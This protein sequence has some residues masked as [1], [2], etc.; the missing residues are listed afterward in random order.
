M[1]IKK[2]VPELLESVDAIKKAIEKETDKEEKAKLFLELGNNY[3]LLSEQGETRDNLV[4]ALLAFNQAEKLSSSV[5]VKDNVENMKGFLFFKLAFIE[6]RSYNLERAIQHYKEA[7]KYRTKEKNL[8]KYASTRYNLGNAYL[9]LRDGNE[10]ENILKA[11][12]EFK[13]AYEIRKEQKNSLEFGV[14]SNALGLSH[15]MLSE[16]ASDPKEAAAYLSEALAYFSDAADVLILDKYP[17]DYAMIQN[18]LGVCFTRLALLGKDREK[19]F[20]EGIKHYKNALNVYTANDFPDDYGT[21][22]Y[23]IGIAY[24]NLSKISPM[25]Y[26]GEYLMNAERHLAESVNVFTESDKTDSFSRSNY[27]L[28][29]VYRDLFEIYKKKEFLEKE[30][31][32]FKNAL[33]GFNEDKTPF[34]YATSYFYIAQVYYGL[35]NKEEAL[36]HYKEARRVAEKFDKKLAKDLDNIIKQIE[37]L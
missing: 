9:S 27:N 6:D 16:I 31:D 34:A 5:F 4:N 20:K 13:S 21:T 19:N 24:H 37:A 3:L 1:E 29:V 10:R 15:L 22:M 32:A 12:D 17:V 25:P 36:S 30:L 28:G 18:N 23:N 35:G 14:I 8:Y 7:L 11:I 26:K 33:E 2:S